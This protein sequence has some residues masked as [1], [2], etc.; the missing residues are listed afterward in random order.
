MSA[1][2]VEAAMAGTATETGRRQAPG[3]RTR[4]GLRTVLVTAG[5]SLGAT[6]CC[7]LLSQAAKAADAGTGGEPVR[8][9]AAATGLSGRLV[10]ALTNAPPRIPTTSVGDASTGRSRSGPDHPAGTTERQAIADSHLPSAP[11][12]A[13]DRTF[14]PH[15]TLVAGGPVRP[16]G[17][18]GVRPV[19]SGTG[20]VP[21]G[22]SGIVPGVPA[23]ADVLPLPD[24]PALPGVSDLPPLADVHGLPPLPGVLDL[25]P[26][27]GVLDLP[28][29]PGASGAP[30]PLAGI[31]DLPVG[32]TV[33]P[34]RAATTLR[35]AAASC[36]SVPPLA[37][38]G[39]VPARGRA[40]SADAVGDPPAPRTGSS[41]G[42]DGTPSGPR[43]PGGPV[44]GPADLR[45]SS[46]SGAGTGSQ[47]S[48]G[49]WT[50]VEAH[51]TT[52]GT[53]PAESAAAMPAS[54]VL[55]PGTTPG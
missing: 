14:V 43:A 11:T 37:T 20:G 35:T 7:L 53:H 28:P 47:G 15:P 18:V 38:H 52:V 42:R 32:P 26:L 16:I 45:R 29:L 9:A 30:A 6:A 8:P 17:E 31:R 3:D 23:L 4:A 1:Q 24:V 54:T 25:P 27:P 34:A 39:A 13:G 51:P 12:R 36:A 40:P 44:P 49:T 48:L 41:P 2:P 33:A 5:L 22:G 55:E 19:Q 50:T 46:A 21:G 10:G